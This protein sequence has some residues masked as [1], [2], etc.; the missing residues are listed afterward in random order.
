[1]NTEYFTEYRPDLGRNAFG[2]FYHDI[3]CPDWERMNV[4]ESDTIA[5]R[6]TFKS[7]DIGDVNK[8]GEHEVHHLIDVLGIYN[9]SQ[10][11]VAKLAKD[12]LVN[13]PPFVAEFI[14]ACRAQR[15]REIP[16]ALRIGNDLYE[17]VEDKPL[18]DDRCWCWARPVV[19]YY[20]YAK[21]ERVRVCE[22]PVCHGDMRVGISDE[23][24]MCDRCGSYLF[25]GDGADKEAGVEADF[26][27]IDLARCFDYLPYI[28]KV[29][30]DRLM[31]Q[32]RED[33]MRMD[34]DLNGSIMRIRDQSRFFV[35][36]RD[37]GKL[38]VRH[39]GIPR[40]LACIKP[41]R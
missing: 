26:T 39:D 8:C 7:M 32:I 10:E 33:R 37:N 6:V 23:S 5:F 3:P 18:Y 34:L 11:P 24:V 25:L 38:H 28:I 31:E 13:L 20:I 4:P 14:A 35:C 29:E 12:H 27:P 21:K 19:R 9:E 30:F 16:A 22:C 40:P 15:A 41:C 17:L 2:T 36:Q 1:M